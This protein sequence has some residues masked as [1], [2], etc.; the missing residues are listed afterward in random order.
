MTTPIQIIY[1]QYRSQLVLCNTC[2]NNFY[3][4]KEKMTDVN[5]AVHMIKDAFLNNFDE[6]ILVSGDSDL[7]PP[8]KV[9]KEMFPQKEIRIAFPPARDSN[10]LKK[11]ADGSFKIGHG[12][13]KKSQLPE[14]VFTQYGQALKR[15]GLWV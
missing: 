10:E 14:I 5:I 6:A 3:D 12:K 7:V 11:T 8:I 9:I 15:P 13:L 2:G 1:G 4:Q